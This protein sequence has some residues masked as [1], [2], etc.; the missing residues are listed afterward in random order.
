[1]YRAVNRIGDSTGILAREMIL[2]NYTTYYILTRTYILNIKMGGGKNW[3]CF[4]VFFYV[5]GGCKTGGGGSWGSR[6][7]SPFLGGRPNFLKRGK[8]TRVSA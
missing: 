5:V 7:L 8:K 2:L 3:K 6:S 1:M 4:E